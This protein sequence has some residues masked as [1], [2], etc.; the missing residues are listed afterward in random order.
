MGACALCCSKLSEMYFEATEQVGR[1]E[2]YVHNTLYERSELW[3][4][5]RRRTDGVRIVATETRRTLRR[6][7]QFARCWWLNAPI[8]G[9]ILLVMRCVSVLHSDETSYMSGHS[10]VLRKH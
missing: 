9:I 3:Y 7:G 6:Y 8:C 5:V 10:V 4:G 2:G 1:G